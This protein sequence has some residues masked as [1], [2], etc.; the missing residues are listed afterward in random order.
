MVGYNIK[1]RARERNAATSVIRPIRFQN[2]ILNCD[3]ILISKIFNV[4]I[5]VASNAG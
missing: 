4:S 2:S 5:Y 3:Q 1:Y